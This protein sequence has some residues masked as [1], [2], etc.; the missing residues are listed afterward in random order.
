M[1]LPEE[2]LNPDTM[3]DRVKTLYENRQEYKRPW[4]DTARVTEHMRLLR[5]WKKS[6]IP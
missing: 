3:V 2:E 5:Y 1:V 6:D 4:Q